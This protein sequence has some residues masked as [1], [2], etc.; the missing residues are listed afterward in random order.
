MYIIIRKGV[1]ANRGLSKGKV[2]EE[3]EKFE[4][5]HDCA[6]CIPTSSSMGHISFVTVVL[7]V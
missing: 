4:V 3:I 5:F 1:E 2:G 7:L 6:T